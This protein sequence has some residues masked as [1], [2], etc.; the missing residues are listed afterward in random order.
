MTIHSNLPS[1][2][3]K[4]QNKVLK[5]ENVQV[6]RGMDKAFEIRANGTRC[7]KNRSWLPLFGNLRNLIMHESHKSKYSI[8]PDSNK[9]YQDLK[10]LY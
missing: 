3:L 6:I 5:E 8:H 4:A 10:K 1:Q 7:I 2:N 9:M